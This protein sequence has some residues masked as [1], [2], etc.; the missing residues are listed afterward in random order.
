MAV[1]V[2]ALVTTEEASQVEIG[3]QK[4]TALFSGLAPGFVGLYQVNAT[5]PQVSGTVPVTINILGV[6]SMPVTIVVK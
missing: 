6:T 3:G 4:A 1:E 2:G 5:V